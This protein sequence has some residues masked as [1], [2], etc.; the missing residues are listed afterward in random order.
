MGC[1]NIIEGKL[2][3]PFHGFLYNK[4]GKVE[5]IPANGKKKPVS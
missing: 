3:C 2:E 1:G 5:L 4:E